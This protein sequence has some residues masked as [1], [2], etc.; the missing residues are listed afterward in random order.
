M[1]CNDEDIIN[2]CRETCQLTSPAVERPFTFTFDSSSKN[3]KMK[4]TDLA[5]LHETGYGPHF[6]SIFYSGESDYAQGTM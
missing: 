6:Y 3:L 5:V 1:A 4:W 2:S